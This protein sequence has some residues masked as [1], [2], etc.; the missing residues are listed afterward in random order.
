MAKNNKGEDEPKVTRIKASD[1]G[2]KKKA[3]PADDTSTRAKSTDN[4][5]REK[6]AHA[7]STRMDATHKF[8]LEKKAVISGEIN[9]SRNPLQAIIRYVKGSWYE[10]RQVRWPN[11]RTTWA[12]TLAVLLFTA[13][14]LAFIVGL[15]YVFQLLFEQIIG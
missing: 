5:K 7:S 11:R 3:A 2:G 10:L 13:F 4:A 9:Q 12:L 14:F 6:K 15:D 8:E 1:G